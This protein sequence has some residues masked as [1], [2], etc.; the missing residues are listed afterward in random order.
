MNEWLCGMSECKT[1]ADLEAEFTHGLAAY[2]ALLN[3]RRD[4]DDAFNVLQELVENWEV[5][6]VIDTL[7]WVRL[8][9]AKAKLRNL[10]AHFDSDAAQVVV[11]PS[12]EAVQREG[13]AP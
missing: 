1:M 4:L 2:I 12:T 9:A 8:V 10:I 3:L 7:Q 6:D 5:M 13:G 11:R